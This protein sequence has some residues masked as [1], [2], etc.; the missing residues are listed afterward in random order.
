MAPTDPKIPTPERP[1]YAEIRFHKLGDKPEKDAIVHEKTGEPKTF[2]G[3]GLSL[4]GRW[5][6]AYES[7]GWTRADISFRDTMRT[8]TSTPTRMYSTSQ[9]ATGG[10]ATA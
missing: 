4:D 2:L 10:R 6:F 9:R 8:S 7:H 5:L 1:G 3:V